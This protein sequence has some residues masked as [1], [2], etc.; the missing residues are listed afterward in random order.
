MGFAKL[1]SSQDV[2][3]KQE[4]HDMDNG[5]RIKDTVAS[6]LVAETRKVLQSAFSLLLKSKSFWHS[7]NTTIFSF[8]M[9]III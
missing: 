7:L 3:Q 9:G 6:R 8:K 2:D 5:E 1:G 4:R